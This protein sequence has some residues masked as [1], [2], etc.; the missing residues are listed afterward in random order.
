MV[1]YEKALFDLAAPM[2]EEP[3]KLKIQTLE[4]VNENEIILCVYA[5]STDTARLIGRGGAM[6]GAIRQMMSI[7]NSVENKKIIIKFES[8]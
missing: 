8:Y 6:A 1:D 7:C 3:D 5:A 2:V 4:T